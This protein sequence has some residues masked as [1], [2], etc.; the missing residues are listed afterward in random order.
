M[1]P[2]PSFLSEVRSQVALAQHALVAAMACG[3]ESAAQTAA[4]R[5]ADLE[6]L[7][8]RNSATRWSCSA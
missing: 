1:T 4:E 8:R 6:E 2:S 5:L 7:A 3:D